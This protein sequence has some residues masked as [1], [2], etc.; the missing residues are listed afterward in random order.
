MD[1]EFRKILFADIPDEFLRYLDKMLDVANAFISTYELCTIQVDIM[2]FGMNFDEIAANEAA[3]TINNSVERRKFRSKIRSR[4]CVDAQ[5]KPI[6]DAMIDIGIPDA[7]AVVY[8]YLLH[9]DKDKLLKHYIALSN[10]IIIHLRRAISK[11]RAENTYLLI[12]RVN[13][14]DRIYMACA[15]GLSDNTQE[16]MYIFRDPIVDLA[17][18]LLHRPILKGLALQ[19]HLYGIN[20]FK[21][22]Y[23]T[24]SP[25]QHMTDLLTSQEF[26]EDSPCPDPGCP[27]KNVYLPFNQRRWKVLYDVIPH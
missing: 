26:L 1:I 24:T 25:L 8:N 3:N 20:E 10:Q 14:L 2:N 15:P 9:A 12:G 4:V 5:I 22:T 18:V 17:D 6:V 7:K 21:P 27:A 16:H 23:L 13:G 19:L 11:N